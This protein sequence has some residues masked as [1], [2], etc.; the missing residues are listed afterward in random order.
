MTHET[1][2]KNILSVHNEF[3]LFKVEADNFP[4]PRASEFG[5]FTGTFFF[6][7][8]WKDNQI[9]FPDWFPFLQLSHSY[10]Q[11][12]DKLWVYSI[13]RLHNADGGEGR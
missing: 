13:I 1:T 8:F 7:F 9:A 6:F 11:H 4:V 12:R 5:I 10:Q 3:I 2:E